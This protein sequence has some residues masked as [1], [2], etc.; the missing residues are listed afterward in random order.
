[1]K[2]S[3]LACDDYYIVEDHDEII[4]T[5]LLNTDKYFVFRPIEGFVYT[6]GQLHSIYNQ[7]SELNTD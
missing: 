5:L 3:F 7:L 2:L 1:M 6:C 4:G